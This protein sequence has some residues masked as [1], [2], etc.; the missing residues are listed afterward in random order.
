[1]NQAKYSN[2]RRVV[3][4]S[5]TLA[6]AFGILEGVL[7]IEDTTPLPLEFAELLVLN[8]MIFYWFIHDRNARGHRHSKFF[9]FCIV[10]FGLLAIAYYL[11]RSRG[12]PA[13]LKSIALAVALYVVSF[14]IFVLT[15]MFTYEF[16]A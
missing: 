11:L 13:G 8:L 2:N 9:N 6:A 3:I 5:L 16:F 14:A 7:G 12:F 10:A 15:W 1:M 4:H